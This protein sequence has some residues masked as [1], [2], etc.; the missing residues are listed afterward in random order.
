MLHHEKDISIGGTITLLLVILNVI[1]L[2]TGFIGDESWYSLLPITLPL[3]ALCLFMMNSWT[4]ENDE[5]IK[6]D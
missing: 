2:R 5:R 1:I 3:L 4:A 6:R